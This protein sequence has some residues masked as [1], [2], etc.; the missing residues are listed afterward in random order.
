MNRIL[1]LL[2]A[3]TCLSGVFIVTC[4]E[5]KSPIDSQDEDQIMFDDY[6][7]FDTSLLIIQRSTSAGRGTEWYL[8]CESS[9]GEPFIDVNGNGVYDPGIDIFVMSVGPDNMDYNN[10]GKH[11]GPDDPWEPDIPFDDHDGDGERFCDADWTRPPHYYENWMPFCDMNGNGQWDSLLDFGY[12]VVRWGVMNEDSTGVEY[13]PFYDDSLFWH[14]T[15]SGVQHWQPGYDDWPVSNGLA[16]FILDD[17]GLIGTTYHHRF[18]IL[19][20]G[21]NVADTTRI[22]YWSIYCSA[23]TIL[24]TVQ[25]NQPLDIGGS[26]HTDLLMVS[27]DDPLDDSGQVSCP[28]TY[29]EFYFAQM[30]GLIALHYNYRGSQETWYYFDQQFAGAQP[31]MNSFIGCQPGRTEDHADM[32]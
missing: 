32:R 19:A 27:F 6:V 13:Q 30:T 9:L 4:D 26:V 1:K 23:T 11:D 17:S 29:W 16:G 25:L 2:I 24:K 8:A 12:K 28:D 22:P 31:M 10:N 14:T 7:F 18:R 5:D 3:A 20:R 21:N 15:D